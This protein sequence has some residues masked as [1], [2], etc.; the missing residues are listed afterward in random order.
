ML[1]GR[2]IAERLGQVLHE[3]LRVELHELH[4]GQP[5]GDLSAQRSQ[6]RRTGQRMGAPHAIVHRHQVEVAVEVEQRLGQRDPRADRRLRP[7]IEAPMQVGQLMARTI[8]LALSRQH[9]GSLGAQARA[10]D[11]RGG[12]G[13]RRVKPAQQPRRLHVVRR[14]K[15]SRYLAEVLAITSAGSAGAGAFLFHGAPFKLACSS[16]SRTN[17]LS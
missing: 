14:V 10:V 2:R 12:R 13:N 16:Q 15:A 9:A 7:L 11:R 5:G 6:A 1:V 8:E 3:T 17:C 4:V